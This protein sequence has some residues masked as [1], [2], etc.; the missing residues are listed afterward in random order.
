MLLL[1]LLA[2]VAALV[3]LARASLPLLDG[4]RDMA[5]L[6]APVQVSRDAAGV[7][8]IRAANRNDAAR[9][10]GFVHAQERFFQ[11]DLMRRRAAGELA[12]LFG[13]AALPLDE[14]ARL[15]G[16]R[17][18]ARREV[19]ALPDAQKQ[20]LR[21]YTE[22]VNQGLDGLDAWP[23]EYLLLRSRPQRWRMEDSALVMFAMYLQ[24][25]A[26][27]IQ[28][29]AEYG[30]MKSLLPASLY[31]FLAPRGGPWDTPLQGAAF[32][33]PAVPAAS[34][35]D[36]R[37]AVAAVPLTLS[38]EAVISGSNS[39]AVSG[40]LT[41]S[42]SAMLANDMHLA[43]GVPNI[44]YRLALQY[45]Q[46][47][48]TRRVVGVSLPGLPV[49]LSG[50]NGDISWGFTNSYA[51]TLDRVVIE[52]APGDAQGYLTPVGVQHFRRRIERIEV[53]GE[54]PR[55]VAFQ[56]TVWGPL[57][58]PNGLGQRH[59]LR[60]IAYDH[61]TL[62]LGMMSLETATR[63]TEALDIATTAAAPVQNFVVG[64]RAGHIGW[65][66]IGPVPRRIGF[67]GRTPVSWADG[68]HRWDGWLPVAEIPRVVDPPAG[69]LTTANNRL[70]G[71]E[72]L[73]RLGDGGYRSGAR[74]RQIDEGLAAAGGNIGEADLLALQLDD[75]AVFLQRWQQLMLT[76]LDAAALQQ[77]PLRGQVA[78]LL[79]DW[80]GRASVGSVGYRLVRRFR[81]EVAKRAF[82]PLLQGITAAVPGFD[83][84][85]IRFREAPLWRL[86]SE[87]PRHLL[88]ASYPDWRALL[89]TAI[90]ATAEALIASA[91]ALP[92][93]TWGERNQVQVQHPFSRLL[94]ILASLLDMPTVQLPGDR[95]MPRVQGRRFG[96]SQRLVVTPGREQ[97][98]IFHM[99]GGQ[100]GHPLS[101]YYRTGFD[102]WVSGIASPLLP[103]AQRHQ[104]TL[105]PADSAG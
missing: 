99:P 25:Q 26:S 87:R 5:G 77:Q 60:W 79:R 86:L 74:A 90:D 83:Y 59:A 23:F 101:R 94:P 73:A 81:N 12:A 97:Q 13:E 22:G 103:A 24:L 91:G 30:L 46:G 10:S 84:G 75:R 44:W 93:A 68:R 3:W 29:E 50:S 80:D 61:G 67:D 42:G 20:L 17:A 56:D 105:R 63:V 104:L 53:A 16:F 95:Y 64:D 55:E 6:S 98:G 11:M 28:R 37:S 2:A 49:I 78:E 70:V 51:D 36:T 96:A 43:H 39:W 69:F 92:L 47:D 62:N 19:A 9:A 21:A 38:G 34:V 88:A 72:A 57:L 35:I 4:E 66:L 102:D 65:T 7:A 15:H 27:G 1:M 52:A 89:L 33:A 14:A 58:A 100:S 40:A 82:A 32:A 48:Q 76:T 71:G 18:H 41:R 8:R 85:D 31:T 45:P 54:E